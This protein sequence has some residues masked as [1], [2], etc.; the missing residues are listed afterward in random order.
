MPTTRN[1]GFNVK[2]QF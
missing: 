1:F 2:I